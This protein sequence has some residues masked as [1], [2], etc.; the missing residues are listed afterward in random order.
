[1]TRLLPL[2][3]P[4]WLTIALLVAVA[5]LAGRAVVRGRFGV[6][7][8]LAGGFALFALGTLFLTGWKYRLVEDGETRTVA[9]AVVALPLAVLL[10]ALLLLL[11]T[12]VW[13]F[14]LGVILGGVLLAGLGG[15]AGRDIS[16]GVAYAGRSLLYLNFIRPWWLVLLVFVPVVFLMSRGSLSGLGPWRK[17]MAVGGRATGVAAIA[18]ALAE[19]RLLR[20]SENVTVLF[21]VDRSFSIPQEPYQEK[22]GGPTLDMRWERTRALIEKSVDLQFT[23]SKEDRFGV[24]LFGKRPK[25]LLPAAPVFTTPLKPEAAGPVD[26]EYTDIAAAFK[27]ALASFPEGTGKRVVLVSDGNPNR[28]VL[29]EQLDLA[30]KNKVE[31]DTVALAPGIRNE[32]EVRVESVDAPALTAEGERRT[33]RVVVRNEHP[34]RIV[35]GT[36]ELL[37]IGASVADG[38]ADKRDPVRIVDSE[39]VL[40][41]TKRPP[42][43]RLMP[44]KVRQNVFEFVD[45][46][47]K[48]RSSYTYR[49][50]FTP[51]RS[52]EPEAADWTPGLAGDRPAN[53]AASTV[54]VAKGKQKMLFLDPKDAAEATSPHRFLI[55]TLRKANFTLDY[56]S[57]GQL[58][59]KKDQLSVFL[60]DYDCIVLADVPADVFE[61]DQMEVIRQQ[62]HDQ[63]CGLVMVGGPDAYGP[64]GYQG[65]PV[66]AALPVDC[67]VKAKKAAGKGGL[68]LIMHASEMA[69]GNQ[70]QKVIAKLAVQRLGAGDMIGVTDYGFGAGGV[71]WPIPFQ[72]VGEDKSVHYAKIDRMTPGDMPDFDPFLTAA[73]NTL[74]DP[75]HN[76]AV[77]H[78]ILIS[79]GD[80][81][82]SPIGQAAIAKMAANNITCTTIGVAT[83]GVNEDKK[84]A[85][86]ASGTKDGSD[87]PGNFHKV[88]N[89]NQLPAIYIR[90]T[91]RISQSFIYDKPF[92]P[93]LI[94]RDGPTVTLNPPLPKLRGMVRTTK[95]ENVLADM[96]IEGPMDEQSG[97]RFPVLAKWRY[98]LGKSVAYTSDARSQPDGVSGWDRE[99]V[100]SDLYTKFWTDT[101]RWAMRDEEKGQLVV[102]TEIRNGRVQVTVSAQ[103][104]DPTT[105]KKRPVSGLSLEGMV[106]LPNP[107][108]PGQPTPKLTFRPKAGSPGQYVAEFTADDAGSYFV[109]V[110]AS[111][112][113]IGSDGKQVR[114]AKGPV[115]QA[116]DSA[117]TG[118]TVPYSPEYADLETDTGRMKRIAEEGGGNYHEE[119]A[120]VA[121]AAKLAAAADFFRRPKQGSESQSPFWY[122]LVFAAAVLLLFDVAVRRISFEYAET[123]RA[124]AGA[125]GR[126]RATNF[127]DEPEDGGM[128]G[129]LKKSKKTV[130]DTLA[131]KK[132]GRRFDPGE[133]DGDVVAPGGADDFGGGPGK[134]PPPPPAG[135]PAPKADEDAGDDFMTRM[136]KAR[137][138]GR[139]GPDPK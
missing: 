5:V 22:P 101:I 87:R 32:N 119:P 100:G 116:F 47:G 43:V 4:H 66:E 76:L 134:P 79:D 64:G 137:D 13:S 107:P 133:G 86:I 124:L 68:V 59:K 20:P 23:R 58:P 16:S 41:S 14:I 67:E 72:E 25:L 129:A 115:I 92:D 128:L 24:M 12:R 90:E 55:R 74:S 80:P 118:T 48:G 75:K 61:G 45:T 44:S 6:G 15:W 35:D 138:R 125:W 93:Q 122:W 85:S 112:P 99:W 11:L 56:L 18:L 60:L 98:G 21:L 17:W 89:P 52:K 54:V 77:K 96:L 106:S 46:P 88:T 27:L 139:R 120:T 63:G 31:V 30:V 104:T 2:L 103:K 7:G 42:I 102:S 78:V 110:N 109:T 50:T 26:G 57:V 53:N 117:R 82:Y 49:A 36:L 33:L 34:T 113:K 39:Q 73:A 51:I 40:D 3:Q 29:A 1:M 19:P 123:R 126:L 127:V 91:R 83:H 121:D 28:G 9:V 8:W 114:D 135:K 37:R 94:L 62:V 71:N 38:Q 65:T 81:Q 108:L 130:A 69:D 70:W 10:F 111:E 97:Q 132:A 131:K 105:N 95:K 84:M 136:K